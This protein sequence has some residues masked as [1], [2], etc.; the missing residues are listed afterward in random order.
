MDARPAQHDAG[1]WKDALLAAVPAWITARAVVLAALAYAHYVADE[2]RPG[3]AAVARTVHEGLLAWD[4]S[5]Y[6]DIA[7]R[8]YGAIAPESLRFFPGF[9]VL[10]RGLGVLLG[11][12]VALV[13]IAN[14][15]ALVA[16]V[17]LYRL[18][19][20]ER[21]DAPLATRAA[22]FLSIAPPA[23]VFVMGY[24]D[25]LA[26]VFAIA[27]FLAMRRGQWWWAA[28]AALAVGVTR[29]TGMLLAV[30]IA[31]EAV[32]SWRA[33][34]GGE[35]RAGASPVVARITAVVAAPIGA[36]VYL[37]WVW[38]QYDDVLL[39]YR[40][41]TSS[42]LHGSFANPFTTVWH[43]VEGGFDG[44]VGTALHVPWLIVLVALVVVVFRRWPLAYGVFAAVVVA[45]SVTS[46]NLDSL[47]R[48]AL[49]AFPLVLAVADLAAHRLV[50]RIVYVLLPVVLFAYATLAWF[51]L[52]VP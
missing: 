33:S 22:W 31:V 39:P 34:S 45:S 43:A 37:C 38:T 27:A 30:P 17:L 2:V 3:R 26:I 10:G 9:P 44:R 19:R 1:T 49:F 6:A 13:V 32:S 16:A 28:A 23:F 7:S 5:W 36:L 52:Y 25:A 14:V 8:G 11:D 15:A 48:Y 4:G 50:E 21:G 51:G 42:R 35:S 40:V 41:Q 24:S 18:V 47:E 20:W 12:R 46:Q 29:P